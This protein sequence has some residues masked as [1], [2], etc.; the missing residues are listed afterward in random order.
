VRFD[1][2]VETLQGLTSSRPDL[3]A[4]L[5]RLRVP[6]EYATLI[7]SAIRDTSENNMRKQTGRKALILLTD[8]VAYKDPVSIGTAIEFAQRADTIL[9][10]IRFADRIAAHRPV[11]A[12]VLK[13]ASAKGKEACSAW[14][15]KPEGVSMR[16]P[17]L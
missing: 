5:M 17:R 12:L 8:G 9:Y 7:F 14:R 6:G 11:R 3:E 4:A 16:S 13:E 10:A 1:R 15:R 2:S